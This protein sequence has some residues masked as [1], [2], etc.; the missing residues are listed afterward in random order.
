MVGVQL[1]YRRLKVVCTEQNQMEPDNKRSVILDLALSPRLMVII[2][3]DRELFWLPVA[4][5]IQYKM[6]ISVNKCLRGLAPRYLAE[7]C[8]QVVHFHDVDI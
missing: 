3:I 5:R 4:E 8:R 7:L 1:E 6:A 2:M